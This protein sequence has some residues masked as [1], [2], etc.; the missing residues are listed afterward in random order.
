LLVNKGYTVYAYYN[1]PYVQTMEEHVEL[2]LQVFSEEA[3]LVRLGRSITSAFHKLLGLG[4]LLH[5]FGKALFEPSRGKELSFTGHEIVSGWMTYRLLESFEV[6]GKIQRKLGMST[7]PLENGALV[8]AVLLHHH[9][10]D[11]T[12]RL[13]N[14]RR[15]K[16]KLT[17]D[18]V[19]AFAQ[20]VAGPATKHLGLSAEL[21][22]LFL[23]ALGAEEIEIAKIY[24][25]TKEVY[26]NQWRKVWLFVKSPAIRRLFLLLL[27]GIV[28]ADYRA[29][30]TR[31]SSTPQSRF[32]RAV[33][34][35][36]GHYSHSERA[37]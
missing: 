29:S 30:R 18:R 3:P 28:A 37:S 15:L 25:T 31:K 12:S 27:Q 16:P 14:F 6:G 26:E 32:A 10:M 17:R 23:E 24:S 9:P 13:E 34:I 2:A 35:F 22:E 4:L 21:E 7:G 20:S 11:F 36:L 8:L 19:K 5:D 33:E 1:P